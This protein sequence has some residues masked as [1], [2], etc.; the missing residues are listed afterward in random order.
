[1][2]RQYTLLLFE[3]VHDPAALR[4][5]QDPFL[6]LLTGL[7]DAVGHEDAF[8]LPNGL[9]LQACVLRSLHQYGGALQKVEGALHHIG[10]DSQML[11]DR[12]VGYLCMADVIHEDVRAVCYELAKLR[13]IIVFPG[14]K[15]FCSLVSRGSHAKLHGASDPHLRAV[16][17]LSVDLFCLVSEG[18]G[19]V[20]EHADRDVKVA[21]FELY[22]LSANG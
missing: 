17:C 12:P 14:F 11:I 3:A 6:S 19:T 1:M 7:F 21:I 4:A 10:I 5:L 16:Y 18:D 20:Q 8:H 13:W 15:R 9:R 22:A 2:N